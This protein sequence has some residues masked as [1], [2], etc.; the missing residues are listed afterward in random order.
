MMI[1]HVS[2]PADDPPRV[3]R[4]LAK[5][6][7]GE[8]M[9]FPP[10]G[11]NAWILWSKDG[12]I[13]L[14]VLPRGAE[15]APGPTGAQCVA[16]AGERRR[17]SETHVALCVE[18]TANDVVA[19]AAREGWKAGNYDRGG[20][21]ESVE[22]WIENSFFIECFDPAAAARYRGFMTPSNWKKTLE[23]IAP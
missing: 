11:P 23:S 17:G 15:F 3:A 6:I 21:F 7:Q 10:G 18:L 12:Q 22:I 9:P 5:L 2:L 19:L 14:Q 4:F 16:A 13:E 1:S 20:F 8:A